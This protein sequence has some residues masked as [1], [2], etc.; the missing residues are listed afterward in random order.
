[1]N[2][3]VSKMHA[4]VDGRP[5]VVV[6]AHCYTPGGIT[7]GS[8]QADVFDQTSFR[9][10]RVSNEKSPA[11]HEGAGHSQGERRLLVTRVV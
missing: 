10:S 11:P 8:D 2:S 4:I 1:M 7:G 3:R 9:R 6:A 5:L